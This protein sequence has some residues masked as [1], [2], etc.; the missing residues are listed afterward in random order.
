MEAVLGRIT[1][2]RDLVDP[3]AN[4]WGLFRHAIDESQGER[5]FQFLKLVSPV[6]PV[7]TVFDL[8]RASDDFGEE[9]PFDRGR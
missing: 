1:P 9:F 7:L 6:R 8:L 4:F 3:D 2:H 5:A